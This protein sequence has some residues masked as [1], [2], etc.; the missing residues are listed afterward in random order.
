[1]NKKLLF[2]NQQQFGYHISY[3]QYCKYLKSDFNITYLCWDYNRKKLVEDGIE[4]IYISRHGNKMDRNIRFIRAVASHIRRNNFSQVFINYFRGCSI[5]PIF[6]NHKHRIHLHIVSASVSFNS[7]NRFIF[8]GVLKLETIFFRRRSIISKGLRDLFRLGENTFILPLGAS[9]IYVNRKPTNKINL[10]Y[11]GTFATR[12]LEETVEGLGIF[13]KQNPDAKIHYIIIGNGWRNEIDLIKEKIEE[14]GLENKVELK[15]Y[16][17]FS[18]L[19]QF[20]EDANFGVSYVPITAFYEYQP[21]TKTFEYLMSGLPVIATD[22]YENRQI[23]NSQNGILIKDNPQAFA[24]SLS[25][26]Y[27]EKRTFNETTIRNSVADYEWKKI[28]IN[29]KNTILS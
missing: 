25:Q 21:V 8:N 1:M 24:L 27:S 26:I 18:E 10:L 2:V 6:F 15:G 13:V 12:R 19:T 16:I 17:P 5:I 7:I 20:I 23:I 29:M 3:A 22:T 4:I 28:V 9:P 11:I 14:F